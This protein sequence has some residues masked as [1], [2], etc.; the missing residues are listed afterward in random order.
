MWLTVWTLCPY[1]ADA[2]ILKVRG[3]ATPIVETINRAYDFDYFFPFEDEDTMHLTVEQKRTALDLRYNS[4]KDS[5]KKMDNIKMRDYYTHINDDAYLNFKLRLCEKGSPEYEELMAKINPNDS[6]ALINYLPQRFIS[7]NMKG[8]YENAWGADLT[9]YGLE[10]ISVMRQYITNPD[11]KHALLI[12]CAREVL[13]YGKNYADIDRFWKPFMEYAAED[14][15]V[16][17][18]YQFK[19]DAI[20]RTKSGAPA[21]DF[22]FADREGKSHRLSEYFGKTLYIDCWATWCGPC[23]REIPF[24]EKQ[25]EAMRDKADRLMFISISLDSNRKAWLNKLDK[26]KPQWPQFLID[27]ESDGILSQ[28]YGITAIPRFLIINPDGTIADADAFRPND[29]DFAE[30]MAGYLRQ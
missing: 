9:D 18:R 17:R 22:T 27:K 26:D 11:V 6:L 5:L 25:V 21:I 1:G 30:K 10:Y 7:Y 20:K 15:I 8:N 12:D 29:G 23:C 16:V 19:V 4:V 14:T 3:Q 28:Q 24:L 2:Q 13:S